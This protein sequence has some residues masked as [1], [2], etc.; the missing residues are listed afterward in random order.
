MQNITNGILSVLNQGAKLEVT[1]DTGYVI[2][3]P[4]F[5]YCNEFMEW[6]EELKGCKGICH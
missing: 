1:C 3:G 2:N 5:V 4:N 6:N